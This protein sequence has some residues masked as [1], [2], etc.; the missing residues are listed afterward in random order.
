V[1]NNERL[2]QAEVKPSRKRIG[3]AAR[4]LLAHWSGAV[5]NQHPRHRLGPPSASRSFIHR[6]QASWVSLPERKPQPSSRS[7]KERNCLRGSPT[8]GSASKKG[9]SRCARQ[10]LLGLS[11]LPDGERRSQLQSQRKPLPGRSKACTR[12][13][14]RCRCRPFAGVLRDMDYRRVGAAAPAAGRGRPSAGPYAHPRPTW[15][16]FR[17]GSAFM[18]LA[19]SNLHEPRAELT[20]PVPACCRAYVLTPDRRPPMFTRECRRPP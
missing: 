14:N 19:R 4:W 17:A 12:T 9:L 8:C 20:P 1:W 10:E 15:R 11:G 5:A 6:W 2:A 16:V 18:V 7:S 13:N 3:S